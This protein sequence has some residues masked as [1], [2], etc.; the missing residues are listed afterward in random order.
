L[1]EGLDLVEDFYTDEAEQTQLEFEV[2]AKSKLSK[3]P[4]SVEDI[5][6]GQGSVR[7]VN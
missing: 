4:S 6:Q 3:E 7:A 1:E 5:Q 2:K